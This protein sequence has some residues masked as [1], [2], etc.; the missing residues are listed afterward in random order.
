MSAELGSALEL[1][2]ALAIAL[3]PLIRQAADPQASQAAYASLC[4]QE[5]EVQAVALCA[6]SA[7]AAA[8]WR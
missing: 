2:R 6:R 3:V 4:L 1:S 8:S 7:I 5:E